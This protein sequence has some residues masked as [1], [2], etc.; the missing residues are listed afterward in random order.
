MALLR[1]PPTITFHPTLHHRNRLPRS[2][3]HLYTERRK[4]IKSRTSTLK[5]GDRLQALQIVNV[6]SDS[7]REEGILMSEVV[8]EQPREVCTGRKWNA[9]DVTKAEVV[10]A[11]H[12]LCVFAPFTFSWR[13]LWLSFGLYMVT[14]LLG[15]TLSFHRH[16]SHKSFKIPK[17]LEYTFAY[18][19]VHALQGD[20]IDW[21]RTHWYHH[22]YCDSERDPHTPTQGFWFSYILWLFDTEKIAN[23]S[24]DPN[25]IEEMEK[26]PFY[27]FLRKTYILHPIALGLLL[28]ALGGFPFI[29]W[30]VGVRTVCL[31]HMTWVLNAVCHGLGHRTWVTSDL[32]R[33]IW[34][35]GVFLFGEGWH[36]N[37][38]AFQYSAKFGL[39]WWQIDMTWYVIRLLETIKVA[40]DVKQPNQIDI[41]RKIVPSKT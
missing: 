19:G 24:G 33:N 17:W 31:Y 36:N 2:P 4:V 18:C 39:E 12:L 32:S 40:T 23:M 25:I 35:L 20:P 41:Q 30:G 37:H 14:G 8:E 7:D 38:H 1:P 21:V 28:Y 15:I 10:A 11:L 27:K 26:Q 5:S 13:A 22:Q 3:S 16:L 34:W 29:V 6:E 9:L